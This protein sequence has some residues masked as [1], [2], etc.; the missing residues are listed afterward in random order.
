[1]IE[2]AREG[3][4]T[5]QKE[6]SCREESCRTAR[7]LLLGCV[8]AKYMLQLSSCETGHCT[9]YTVQCTVQYV[10]Y[11]GPLNTSYYTLILY[12]CVT[13]LLDNLTDDANALYMTKFSTISLYLTKVYFTSHRALQ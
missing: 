10:Q 6:I 3:W 8:H 5:R 4:T 11:S 1:M 2:N 9:V 12:N 7:H 13:A